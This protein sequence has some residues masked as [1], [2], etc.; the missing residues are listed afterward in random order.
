MKLRKKP[1]VIEGFQMTAERMRMDGM[2]DGL[3]SWAVV[4]ALKPEHEPGA[5]YRT[6]AALWYVHTLDG[7]V[8]VSVDNWILRGVKGEL[9]P[10]APDI[11]A[12]TYDVLGP[13]EEGT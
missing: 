13:D 11:L 4:A 8:R 5:I 7:P 3:P 6:P 10:C 12:L 2:Y 9:Y 1:V